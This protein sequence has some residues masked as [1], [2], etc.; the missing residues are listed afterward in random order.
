MHSHLLPFCNI[1]VSA[2]MKFN[3][4]VAA[5]LFLPWLAGA[6]T[7]HTEQQ[8]SEKAR[9][10][11]YEGQA[12]AK[13]GNAAVAQG[14]FEQALKADT[15]FIN[16]KLALAEVMAD[17]GNLF[18]AEQTF[19][20]ALT[21]A[22]TYNDLTYFRLAEV[23][24]NL[25][26][27]D[28]AVEHLRAFLKSSVEAP[29]SRQRAEYYLK[30]ALFIL[31][32]RA[33]PTPFNPQ[34]LGEG[35]NTAANEYFPVLTADGETL[36]FTRQDTIR[37]PPMNWL[38]NDENFYSAKRNP[39]SE[40]WETARPLEGV[41]TDQNE[42]AQSISPDG[43]WLVFTA[44][45][46]T[47]EGAQGSCDL[48]W[49]VQRQEGWSAPK[50][51]SGTINGRDWDSQ[52]C[53]SA[54]GK[55]IYFSSIRTGGFGGA[56]LWVTHRQP[57]GRWTPPQNLGPRVNTAGDENAPYLHPDGRTLY[58][59]SNGHIGMG[60]FDLFMTQ[61]ENDSAW[62]TPRNLG[63]PINTKADENTLFVSLDG[64]TAYFAA[65]RREDRKDLDIYQFELP[66]ALRPAAATYAKVRVRDAATGYPLQAKADF[67]DLA[68]G[69]T[70]VSATTKSDGTFLVCLPAGKDYALNVAKTGYFFH[71][72]NF[73]LLETASF[74][75]PFRLQVE[76]Q[77]LPDSAAAPEPGKPIVLR[78]V[79]FETGSAALQPASAYELDR[80]A[81]LL[82][83][84]PHLKIRI[85]GHTDQIGNE[86]D[87][88]R[89]SE[90]RARAVMD[91]LIGKGIAA[92]RLQSKGYGESKPLESNDTAEG[93]AANRRTEFE[94]W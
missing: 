5:L 24:W 65:N 70:Y 41:N 49:S 56:D 39:E 28:D 13:I 79:F 68:T 8:T 37:M 6:Q 55:A 69:Q 25:E 12:Q 52:P 42:G 30:R 67:I 21:M 93:R 29:K 34:P 43:S 58:F 53:I 60:G 66:P 16:A 86:A 4:T 32:A 15:L 45:N 75:Q 48:Y 20:E 1:T 47:D 71:S 35:V 23:E 88:L 76:L 83:D 92:A 64:R 84:H 89:L 44:C 74:D 77:P 73:N 7:Y 19:E 90:L 10:A 57:N 59:S 11:F 14:Y 85:N 38:V 61:A 78:N 54:D 80:L 81:A 82:A 50:P 33:T 94:I 63:F 18:K 26:K 31:D 62:T 3:P 51:F 46:R 2:H 9:K 22:P 40:S 72:E 27:Y 91:Y 36:I 87:N 17:Q